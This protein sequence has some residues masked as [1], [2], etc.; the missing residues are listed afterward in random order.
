MTEDNEFDRNL[1]NEF[2]DKGPP[3]ALLVGVYTDKNKKDLCEEH[4]NELERLTETYG[5]VAV[6]KCPTF[7][8]KFEPATLLT[9]GKLEEIQALAR[10][11]EV[12][13]VIFDDEIQPTQQR[14][15]EEAFGKTVMDR[16]EVIL[17]VFGQRAQTKE[18][19]I[20]IELA[21]VKYQAPRLKRLWTHLERQA[22]GGSGGVFL[23]GM[24]EKQIEIDRRLLS[25]Q[26]RKLE[27]SLK[28]I[29]LHREIQRQERIRKGIPTFAIIGYTNA[30]KSTLL[31]AL[32]EAEVFVED[33]L[34]ATLDTTTRKFTLPNKQ[35]ILLVD[36]VGFIRKIPHNLVAAFRS[37][38]EEAVHT[39]ILLHLVDVSHPMALEQIEATEHVLKELN[40]SD[41][42]IITVLNKIDQCENPAILDRLRIQYPRTV[43]ISALK[44]TGFED[45]LNI[46]VEELSKR[47]Q[48][49]KLRVPQSKYE[50][51]SEVMRSGKVLNQDYEENDVLIL[52]EMP[53]EMIGRVEK[54]IEPPTQAV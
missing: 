44:R 16:T 48:V 50:V 31:N 33:K 45:L 41:K 40:A 28:D 24:G 11:H 20:Q 15:L 9:K 19:Q 29:Q 39:D 27:R 49:V 46:M 30:G 3:K 14:N 51:V 47:R 1:N 13:I 21:K 12:D 5:L 4:L 37:T 32:T 2:E 23:K 54:F 7:L 6:E 36:T 25:K 35:D 43:K 52:V 22:G 38:L 26:M 8:R 10:A 17:E 34:F 42:P 53:G 18:A